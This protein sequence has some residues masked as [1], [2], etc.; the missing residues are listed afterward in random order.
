VGEPGRYVALVVS[1]TGAEPTLEWSLGGTKRGAMTAPLPAGMQAT[2]LELRV[3]PGSGELTALVGAGRDQRQLGER[4]ML[5]KG[6]KALFGDPPK[7]AVGCLEGTCA[8]KALLV[9]GLRSPERPPPPPP[10]VAVDDPPEKPAEKPIAKASPPPPV[11]KNPPPPPAK[12]PPPV[13]K[14]QAQPPKKK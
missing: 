10:P 1:G 4:L 5:G 8:F 13:T 14:K 6:W 2:H 3:E 7:P 9:E 12:Q 11:K